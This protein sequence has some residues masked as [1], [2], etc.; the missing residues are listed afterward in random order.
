MNRL[1]YYQS[2][3]RLLTD[4]RTLYIQVVL[5]MVLTQRYVLV[6]VRFLIITR[7]SVHVARTVVYLLVASLA[8]SVLRA[9]I[10]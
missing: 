9:R 1:G 5:T 10:V 2:L 4:L 6:G 8:L 3:Q 7:I